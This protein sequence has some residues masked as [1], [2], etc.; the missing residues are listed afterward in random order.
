MLNSCVLFISVIADMSAGLD[1]VLNP[2]KLYTLPIQDAINAAVNFLVDNYRPIFQ[3]IRFPF[4]LALDGI[5]WVFIAIPPLILLL[6]IGLTIWQLAGRSIALYSIVGLISL[7]FLGVWEQTMMTLSLMGTAV[8]FCAALGIPVGIAC[9]RS[10]KV[11]QFV[12]P[13][14]DFMQTLPLFIYLVPVVMLFG[15]GKVPGVIATLI[16]AVPPVIRLTNLGIR[17]VSKELVEA[18]IAF[19]ST[20]RQVL[21]EV[22]LPLAM[23]TILTGLNQTIMA[24]L[25]MT[26]VASMISVQG[27]GMMV[28]Q[29]TSSMN[30]GLAAVGGL[31]IVVIAIMLDRI[32]QA[33]GQADSQ[34]SWNKRGPIGFLLSQLTN[35]KKE[36]NSKESGFFEVITKQLLTL[37][38]IAATLL[39]SLIAFQLTSKVTIE[40]TSATPM[41]GKGV[42]VRSAYDVPQQRFISEIVDI[43]L[44][45]LGYE[46]QEPNQI[47]RT[48]LLHAAF[49]SGD[50][51][52]TA[53]HWEKLQETFFKNSGGEEKLERV[54]L[55]TPNLLQGYQ[56][57]KKTADQYHIT[58]LG[59]LKDPK[60]ASLF[61]SDGD[62]KANLAGCSPGWGCDEIINHHLD[63]YGLGDTVEHDQGEISALYADL[64]ARYKQGNSVLYFTWTPV[65]LEAILKP[66]EKAIWLEVPFTSLPENFGKFTEK[67]TS[68]D[69]KNIGF[70]IDRLRVEATKQ[71]LAA[72]PAAKRL[73]ELVQIPLEDLYNQQLLFHEGEN[74]PAE[75]HRHAE[76]WV[77]KHQEL[78]DSWLEEARK[79]GGSF[80]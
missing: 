78:F 48:A 69:G 61:D 5:E 49:N 57:D 43:G 45:K 13:L 38:T 12:R 70:V 32:T 24:A 41:P 63:V 44:E 26:V 8:L 56:I 16:V 52:F 34:N 60:I 39:I 40:A 18:A 36:E 80:A 25:S 71:F 4:S 50:I 58:N 20:P 33:V 51:D 10:D 2:F 66:G 42:I 29:G 46:V 72:N 9:A 55:I 37:A 77:K 59:Q 7:G 73:F 19:G 11:D 17:Q 76:K 64:I 79:A 27:L 30:V 23:P 53:I 75:I 74:S 15:I 65:W 14:L 47:G 22:L 6:I 68:V 67:D 62:G 31:G 54:G 35:N 1:V 28:L 3:A 21:G